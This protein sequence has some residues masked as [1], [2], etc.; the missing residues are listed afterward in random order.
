MYHKF[1]RIQ[2]RISIHKCT[3]LDL[4]AMADVWLCLVIYKV[5]K[6]SIPNIMQNHSPLTR[7][8]SNFNVDNGRDKQVHCHTIV[9]IQVSWSVYKLI[10]CITNYAAM[11]GYMVG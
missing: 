4:K 8:F 10:V 2:D 6:P 3:W 5:V 1:P 9:I 7:V 11:D